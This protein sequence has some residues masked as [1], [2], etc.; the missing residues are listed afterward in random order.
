MM[1]SEPMPDRRQV[2]FENGNVDVLM[3]PRGSPARLGCPPAGH[4]PLEGST[5]ESPEDLRWTPGS[6]RPVDLLQ[7][8]ERHVSAIADN[9]S[10]RSGINLRRHAASV[11]LPTQL[12]LACACDD[13]SMAESHTAHPAPKVFISHAS[14]DKER[15]VLAFAQRLRSDGVDA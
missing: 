6:P 9:R 2:A 12:V 14:E 4:P 15:F 11:G 13:G 10:G 8:A 1:V 3:D 7:F 5:M